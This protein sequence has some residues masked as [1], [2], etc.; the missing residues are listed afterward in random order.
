M[1]FRS[2]AITGNV[3]L[4]GSSEG[5]VA[6][7]LPEEVIAD[8]RVGRSNC[9]WTVSSPLLPKVLRFK[10][11]GRVGVIGTDGIPP[12]FYHTV[13][14][15]ILDGDHDTRSPPGPWFSIYGPPQPRLSRY[16]RYW[17]RPPDRTP[18]QDGWTFSSVAMN[19]TGWVLDPEGRHRCWVPAEWRG[20]LDDEYWHHDITTVFASTDDGQFIVKF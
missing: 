15:D 20:W 5:V 12:F 17:N 4:V 1:L 13:T 10:L 2:L 8:K 11:D 6:W 3:L 14:G 9:I 18:A 19:E 7:L 16:L